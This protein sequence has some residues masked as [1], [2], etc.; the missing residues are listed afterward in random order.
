MTVEALEPRECFKWFAA[1]ARIPHGSH[2]EKHI[3]EWLVRFAGERGLAA[4]RDSLGNVCIKK[5]ASAGMEQAPTVILQGHMDMVCVKEEGRSFDF[6]NDPLTLKVDGDI[7]T[8]DGT[9]LGADNGI[10]LAYILALLDAGDIAHPPLEAVFTVEEE[11][12]MTGA[13][14]FDVAPLAGRFFINIDSEEEGVFCVSCAGG[15]RSSLTLPVGTIPFTMV[16]DGE[17]H[18]FFRISLGGLAG[19]HSG[20]EIDKQRGNA[21]RLMGRVLAALAESFD[22][23]LVSIA[24]GSASNVIPSECS[25]VVCL[26]AEQAALRDKLE[27]VAGMLRHELRASDGNGLTLTATVAVPEANVLSKD[28]TAKVLA[29][30]I[31]IPDGVG[32][33][34]LGMAGERM[35]ESSTNLGQVTMKDGAVVFGSLTRS[36]VESRKEFLYSQIA[37]VAGLVGAEITG[38]GDYPAWEYSPESPLRDV[39]HAAHA[40]LFGKEARAEGIHAGL[41][42]GLFYEKFRALGRHVDFIAFGP[43]ITGAHTVKEAASI[44]SVERTWRLL[45][46]VLRMLGGMKQYSKSI[47]K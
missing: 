3:G 32:S 16:E 23:Y 30:L 14:G 6:A 2:N 5:P 22:P 41:E 31:L 39:F 10:A 20:M 9:T 8:A 1:I 45:L 44:A 24:G 15:R 28:A 35:V 12:G 47:L 38:F 34:D 36:S 26:K 29:A 40:S 27:E 33:M 4:T 18:A 21:N 37:A 46:E 11:V 7:L 43:N 19:G 25:A 42:C 17:R 13:A